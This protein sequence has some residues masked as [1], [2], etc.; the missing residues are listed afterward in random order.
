MRKAKQP[1]AETQIERNTSS[2]STAEIPGYIANRVND[3]F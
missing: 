2:L 3:P 1:N